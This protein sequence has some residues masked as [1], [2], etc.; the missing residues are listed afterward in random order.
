[1]SGSIK[2]QYALDSA[3]GQF[4]DIEELEEKDRVRGFHCLDCKNVVIPVMGKIQQRHF[5]HKVDINSSCSGE[6]QVHLS[7]K[8]AFFELYNNAVKD[9]LE[10]IIEYNVEKVCNRYEVDN[11]T[12]CSIGISV[13]RSDLTKDYTKIE[14]EKRVD[15]FIPDLL[16]ISEDGEEK[17]FIEIAFT[18]KSTEEK[19]GSKYK[20]IEIKI[21]DEVNTELFQERVISEGDRIN[22]YNFQKVFKQRFC[23]DD[24]FKL[25]AD[26]QENLE[27]D[28][29]EIEV[30][31]NV[32]RNPVLEML[33]HARFDRYSIISHLASYDFFV[34]YKNHESKIVKIIVDELIQQEQ[35]ISYTEFMIFPDDFP[36]DLVIARNRIYA[37]RIIESLKMGYRID[38]CFICQHHRE[39]HISDI[40]G[41]IYCDFFYGR[42]DSNKAASCPSYKINPAKMELDWD[43]LTENDLKIDDLVAYIGGAMKYKNKD[44]IITKAYHNF[45]KCKFDGK[46]T[47]WLSRKELS[48]TG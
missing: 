39:K 41:E 20:I 13:A 18:H 24:C 8:I 34:V 6:S 21:D 36:H 2:H 26:W 23:N 45:Y 33:N 42:F 32:L 9:K 44:G 47:E 46:L 15:R 7:T 25:Q 40:A 1:M 17:I 35:S 11:L 31:Q 27:Y 29:N 10:F 14:M 12:D 28:E 16:L 5:R 19:K 30:I 22:F 38:N 48:L 3:I 37:G 43:T 4:V